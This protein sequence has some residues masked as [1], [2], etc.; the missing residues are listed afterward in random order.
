MGNMILILI[1]TIQKLFNSLKNVQ[2][3]QVLVPQTLLNKYSKHCATL[4]LKVEIY[5]GV[6][7]LIFM[8]LGGCA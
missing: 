3:G 4:T 1:Y 5:L 8:H 7:V 2:F 6:L